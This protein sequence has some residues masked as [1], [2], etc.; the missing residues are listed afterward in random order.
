MHV[1]LDASYSETIDGRPSIQT[2][3]ALLDRILCT[4]A[5]A[6]GIAV[7]AR[8]EGDTHIDEHHSAEDVA[9]TL[10]QCVQE[11]LGDKAGLVRMACAEEGYG[12]AR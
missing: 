6:A 3:V 8:C 10:G 4:W 2:G 7:V 11:A 1:N 5:S 12:G 9:I